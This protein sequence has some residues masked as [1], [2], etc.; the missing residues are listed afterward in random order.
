LRAIAANDQLTISTAMEELFETCKSIAIVIEND[1]IGRA[2]SALDGRVAL[3]PASDE[4]KT[5]S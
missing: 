3:Q 2:A 1:E 4:R 5:A